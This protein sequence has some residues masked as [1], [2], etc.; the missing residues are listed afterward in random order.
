ME[1]GVV[2]LPDGLWLL[3]LCMQNMATTCGL[4]N[5]KHGHEMFVRRLYV[6]T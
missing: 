4:D 2:W 6:V 5:D 1:K 3:F